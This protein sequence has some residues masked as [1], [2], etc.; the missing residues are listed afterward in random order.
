MKCGLNTP[1]S[2]KYN[3]YTSNTF[4]QLAFVS[5]PYETTFYTKIHWE[6]GTWHF[7]FYTYRI[8]YYN[9]HNAHIFGTPISEDWSRIALHI[10]LTTLD[11]HSDNFSGNT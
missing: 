4:C 7:T 5:L 10:S 9:T 11:T 1:I 8:T 6:G 3:L 2:T